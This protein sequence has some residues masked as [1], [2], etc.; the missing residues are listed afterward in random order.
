MASLL[1]RLGKFASHRRWAVLI[2]WVVLLLAAAGAAFLPDRPPLGESIKIPG[3][4]AQ[5]AIDELSERIPTSGGSTG[6]MVFAA[7]EG[8]KLTDPEYAAAIGTAIDAVS[9]VPGVEAV[10]NPLTGQATLAG[11]IPAPS[12]PKATPVLAPPSL[13]V[14][15]A[16]VQLKGQITAIPAEA[17]AS[18]AE[19]AGTARASGLQVELSGAAVKQTPAIGST[20]GL[21]VIVALIVLLITFGSMV[22]AGLPLLTAI[23]GIGIG[24]SLTTIASSW[25]E[26]TST[27]PILALM[28]GLAVGIDYA[29]FIV[30]RHRKQMAAGMSVNE[31]IGRATGTAGSAVV[32]AGL[33]VVIALAALTV[34]GIPF[35]SVM[36]VAAA[37]TVAIAVLI[38]ITLL[39]AL[40][41]FAGARILGRKG[42]AALASTVVSDSGART[43]V[44]AEGEDKKRGNRWGALVTKYPIPV[45][46]VGILGLLVM[47][48]PTTKLH[49]SLPD[50]GV[51]SLDAT[52]RKAYDLLADNFGPGFNGPLII[53]VAVDDAAKGQQALGTVLTDLTAIPDVQNAA[54]AGAS[55][56]KTFYAI[57]VVPQSGPSD[58]ATED[59][60]HNIRDQAVGWGQA[61]GSRIAVTGQTAV[62]ID[63]SEKLAAAL[64]V[65]LI[66]V[67]G[68]ALVLLMLVFR[69]IVVPIKAALGFLLSIAA[70]FGSVVAIYQWG[71]FGLIETPAPIVAFLP[72]LLTGVLFGLA[73]DY[74]VFLVSG[75]RESFVHGGDAKQAVRSGFTHGARV[76]T[77][78]AIIMTSVFAGF[79]LAPDTIIASIGFALGFG[80]LIDAFVVRMTLVPAAMTL[81][82]N[83][84]WYLPKWLQKSLP[85]VDIEGEKLLTILAEDHDASAPEV[86]VPDVN[87]GKHAKL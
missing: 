70:A 32:F 45:L 85:N 2:V 6:R 16:T 69:S 12:N 87:R 9:K 14:G 13:R 49:L 21:G 62:V 59:L 80:V 8:K 7:P 61:T 36:G 37:G 65:Y 67:I 19:I 25:V 33:T 57:S 71:W 30:S 40:L 39:P 17:Q 43:V 53:T 74:E 77:A 48:I 42:R 15:F 52:N 60:V 44:A 4:A 76:V 41:S 22:A 82:G 78:A 20:E 46:L 83:A 31:S 18:L 47:A 26:M 68:L 50:D 58:S 27:A 23:L 38:A 51:K 28:L 10:V 84:A 54:V 35:L 79:I 64:P 29:L 81:L 56:D 72:I 86:R 63:V 5:T 75:M 24:V 1:Y 11:G 3:T 66:I 55:V 34:V 73:M